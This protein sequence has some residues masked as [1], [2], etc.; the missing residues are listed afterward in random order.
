MPPSL[1]GCNFCTLPTLQ[2]CGM[3]GALPT[4]FCTHPHAPS[5]ECLT[6]FTHPRFLPSPPLSLRARAL[7]NPSA[8]KNTRRACLFHLLCPLPSCT[9]AH[10]PHYSSASLP[11]SSD[12]RRACRLM[13]D[14]TA[15]KHVI[16]MTDVALTSSTYTR[17]GRQ[18][19]RLRV[20]FRK[21]APAPFSGARRQ[22]RS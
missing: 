3:P 16:Y 21:A 10:L 4:P 22:P 1:L 12:F 7:S 19:G 8:P 9:P 20:H 18:A 11:V 17:Q 2:G 15:G 13:A 14:V 5:L 6:S